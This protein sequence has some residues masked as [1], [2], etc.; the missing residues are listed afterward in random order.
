[1]PPVSLPAPGH[2]DC[3]LPDAFSKSQLKQEESPSADINGSQN[4]F[5]GRKELQMVALS[6]YLVS[7]IHSLHRLGWLSPNDQDQ[8]QPQRAHL[9]GQWT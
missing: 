7:S 9:S 8:S 5:R 1:M 4:S 2:A 3:T 6:R